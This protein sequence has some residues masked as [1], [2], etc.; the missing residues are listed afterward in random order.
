MSVRDLNLEVLGQNSH[1]CRSGMI[2]ARLSVHCTLKRARGSSKPTA[3]LSV[4]H[5]CSTLMSTLT[6]RLS[7]QLLRSTFPKVFSWFASVVRVIPSQIF[8]PFQ[9]KQKSSKCQVK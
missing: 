2:S 7:V 9:L 3:R 5:Q 1:F 6:T 8:I 4:Q